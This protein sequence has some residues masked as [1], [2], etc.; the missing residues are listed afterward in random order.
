[1][2]I[3]ATVP[4]SVYFITPLLGAE[5][6]CSRWMSRRGKSVLCDL[7][8]REE[9]TCNLVSNKLI[10]SLTFIYISHRNNQQGMM[11]D[12]SYDQTLLLI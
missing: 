1:M 11:W 12:G 8:I 4:I 10:D 2:A 9:T 6:G 3:P 7:V 5:Y